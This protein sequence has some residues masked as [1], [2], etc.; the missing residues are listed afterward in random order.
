MTG[1]HA[2]EPH[3]PAIMPNGT[4]PETALRPWS[5]GRDA[6]H[7][8][9]A[10][11]RADAAQ[12]VAHRLGG[13]ARAPLAPRLLAACPSARCA[14]S[15]E[16]CVQPDPWAAP[17]G[18]RSPLISTSC[19]PSK[20]HVGGLVA[21][22][23]GDDHRGGPE[24]V[25]RARQASISAPS[26]APSGAPA[27][28]RASGTF[29]VTTVARGRSR[30]DERFLRVGRRA[31]RAPD[32]ATITGSTTTGVPA[33][34]WS[35]AAA[36][37]AIV[38]RR[39]EHP[40]L[41]RVDA[42]V[43]RD[44][45][46]LGEDHVR[47]YGFDRVDADGVLRGDRGDRASCRAR[48]MRAKALRSA[49]MPAPPPESEPAIDRQTGVGLDHGAEV[50]WRS[51][52]DRDVAPRPASA[53]PSRAAPARRGAPRTLG[54]CW[55]GGR[56]R[57][58]RRGPAATASKS[59]A[60]LGLQVRRRGRPAGAFEPEPTQVQHILGIADQAAPSRSSALPPGAAGCQTGPAP[61]RRRGPC[62]IANRR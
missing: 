23:A 26:P 62:A 12:A 49:W 11:A 43:V 59:S 19:S 33:G 35:S 47:R 36:T 16:E 6:Q 3:P 31:A 29:G 60:Q 61:R 32:S 18:W 7:V 57:Q 30:C 2:Q 52:C 54:G 50:S 1:L 5:A 38:S 40:D 27:S 4:R 10:R 46:D 17:S 34:S 58:R 42:D 28:T 48:R 56:A 44:R 14:A 51:A 55:S 8:D 24:R 9:R 21:V 39:S 37:A 53:G 45:G 22:P 15:A 25:D 41:H 20:Q 13:D